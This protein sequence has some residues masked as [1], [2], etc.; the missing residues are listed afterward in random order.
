MPLDDIARR[1][2]PEPDPDALLRK[3]LA[4][5][6]SSSAPSSWSKRR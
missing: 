5:R 1:S 2:W 6:C 4:D 3:V